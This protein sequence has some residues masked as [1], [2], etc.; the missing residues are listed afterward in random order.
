MDVVRRIGTLAQK[1]I[2]LPILVP[3]PC[4]G[5]EDISPA[6]VGVLHGG[7]DQLR[8]VRGL[9][10]I[11]T[12]RRPGIRHEKHLAEVISDDQILLPRFPDV[13]C[14][15][16]WRYPRVWIV[17]A[18][19][20]IFW[21]RAG[22]KNPRELALGELRFLRRSAIKVDPQVAQDIHRDDVEQPVGVHVRHAHG[23]RHGRIGYRPAQG[24]NGR[25]TALSGKISGIVDPLPKILAPG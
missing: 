22:K 8:N 24:Q 4:A 5:S 3:V 10:E 14:E 12:L 6:L 7:D 13:R 9:F 20:G 2:V 21:R 15:N 17:A 11:G 25:L 23:N 1:Q 16:P 19:G 18:D